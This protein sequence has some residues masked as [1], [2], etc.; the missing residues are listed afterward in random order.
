MLAY[1]P[2]VFAV[3]ETYQ[4]IALV[5]APCLFW[6]QV[7][8]GVY[9][10]QQNGVMR[11]DT[12]VH[13]VTVPMK[14]LDEAGSYTVRVKP[15]TERKPYF[16]QTAREEAYTFSFRAVP[17][18]GNIRAYHIADAHGL[19]T[20]PIEAAKAFGD[21]DIL[22]LNGDLISYCD[23]KEELYGVFALMD[24][25][26]KGGIPVVYARGNHDLRGRFAEH[27]TAYTPLANGKPYFT[28]RLGRI[29][30]LILDCAEDKPDDHPEYGSTVCC[31]A[32]REE[33]TAFL[34]AVIAQKAY[35]ADGITTRVLISHNPFT[36]VNPSPFDIETDLYREWAR[37]IKEHIRPDVMLSGHQHLTQVF[38]VGGEYDHL[39]QPCPLVIGGTYKEH[40]YAGAGITFTEN[41]WR[42]MF[43]D[44]HHRIISG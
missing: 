6:V 24:A 10:D 3:E 7:G 18:K 27:R 15:V 37:L 17:D 23:Q 21:I 22:I 20:E 30:G 13:R 38:P 2:A 40:Y 14:V 34:Q 36:H 9:G 31:R 28:F 39:G 19:V 44:S 8:D 25:I 41:G 32:F 11:S 35:E 43:T 16:T 26:T 29:W 5:K 42:I 1:S 4:I 33:Q 12:E